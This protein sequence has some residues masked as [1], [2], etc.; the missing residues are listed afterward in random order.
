LLPAAPEIRSVATAERP[1]PRRLRTRVLV[2][3]DEPELLASIV[4]SLADTHDVV[5]APGGSAAL[6]ILGGDDH[7][8]AVLTDV[9]MA[10]ITGMDLYDR[11]RKR[12]P[13]LER[14]FLFM[15]GGAFTRRV[16]RFVAEVPNRCLAKPFERRQ[17]LEAVDAVALGART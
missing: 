8:D 6:E 15:T 2:I 4:R 7:F 16:Q 11:V 9:M 1:A 5:T 12:H 14:R 3:D 17:L 10:D 13:G